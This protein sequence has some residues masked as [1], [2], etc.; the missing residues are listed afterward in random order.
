[1]NGLRY[2]MTG[3]EG[4]RYIYYLDMALLDITQCTAYTQ[5]GG[6]VNVYFNIGLVDWRETSY[7]VCDTTIGTSYRKTSDLYLEANKCVNTR[8]SFHMDC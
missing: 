7:P 6:L 1:M 3:S 4:Q 5:T 2:N 8:Y